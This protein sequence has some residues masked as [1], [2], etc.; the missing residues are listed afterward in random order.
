MMRTFHKRDA[1]VR[2]LFNAVS[3]RIAGSMDTFVIS[4]IVTGR[5][6]LAGA[7]ASVEV[8]TKIVLF[9]FHERIWETIRWG[10]QLR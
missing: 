6:E 7:I 1:H 3:W 2:S 10:Q 9:Y 5:I 4:F 8:V